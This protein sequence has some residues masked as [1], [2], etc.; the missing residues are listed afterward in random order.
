V[1]IFEKWAIEFI[2][3]IISPTQHSYARYIITD[4]KYLTCWAEVAPIKDFTTNI[5]ARF[6]FE[7]IISRFGCPKILTS[8]QGTH[9]IIE[10]VYSFLTKIMVQH[11][12]S[13]PD[14]PQ[15]NGIVEAFNKI[16]EKGLKKLYR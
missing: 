4:T 6:I 8:D 14:H 5:S 7:C 11:H 9:F 13:C 3:P 2:D 15:V 16:L 1:Q 12:K 10:N